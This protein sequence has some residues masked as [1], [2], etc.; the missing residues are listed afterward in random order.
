[1]RAQPPCDRQTD[2]KAMHMSGWG[3]LR[4]GSIPPA[5]RSRRLVPRSFLFFGCRCFPAAAPSPSH[6]LRCTQSRVHTPGPCFT[7]ALQQ[8]SRTFFVLRSPSPPFA[9]SAS[10]SVSVGCSRRSRLC[11]NRVKKTIK[12]TFIYMNHTI[13]NNF[14]AQICSFNYNLALR[15]ASDKGEK[16][17]RAAHD[18]GMRRGDFLF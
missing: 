17:T 7:S 2:D 8:L 1:M 3:A 4:G 11:S 14:S 5:T 10:P 9:R 13:F 16:I 15:K 6:S 18:D 12:A